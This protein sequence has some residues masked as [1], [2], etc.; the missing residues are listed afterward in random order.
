MRYLLT[1]IRV[2]EDG[3]DA[4]VT[5]EQASAQRRLVAES[6]AC[7]KKVGRSEQ[8]TCATFWIM[9]RRRSAKTCQVRVCGS[10]SSLQKARCQHFCG[11]ARP[12][13]SP[14]M[15]EQTH[16]M[17]NRISGYPISARKNFKISAVSNFCLRTKIRYYH[18]EISYAIKM[19]RLPQGDLTGRRPAGFTTSRRD[20]WVK[21]EEGNRDTGSVSPLVIEHP[22]HENNFPVNFSPDCLAVST[23][24][25][26]HAFDVAV[27]C[28]VVSVPKIVF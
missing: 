21:R 12:E 8:A 16:S 20:G 14:S 10:V 9:C 19:Y 18:E 26:A 27:K 23:R 25:E 17:V 7:G 3:F 13:T 5:Q 6:F 15:S 1:T 22:H 28:G 2:Q 24:E 4:S 11:I